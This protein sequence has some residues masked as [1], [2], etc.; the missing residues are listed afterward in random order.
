MKRV[1]YYLQI[2]VL[3]SLSVP[4]FG[5]FLSVNG[6]YKMD[7]ANGGYDAACC[8][9]PYNLVTPD[10]LSN[11]FL[12]RVHSSLPEGTSALCMASQY[13]AS[14]AP[15]ALHLLDSGDVYLTYVGQGDWYE[16]VL[17]FYTFPWGTPP[18]SLADSQVTV[19]FPNATLWSSGGGLAIGN[20]VY[21]GH[22][23]ANTGFGF[24]LISNG[25]SNIYPFDIHSNRWR[26]DS[27]L[28]A[29]PWN[30]N[31]PGSDIFCSHT[32]LNKVAD[33]DPADTMRHV[34]A[35]WDSLSGHIVVGMEDRNRGANWQ[36]DNDFND[37]VFYLTG[38]NA[39][40]FDIT[41]CPHTLVTCDSNTGSGSGGGL[42]S[43]NLGGI[44]AKHDYEKIKNGLPLHAKPDYA[45]TPV[46]RPGVSAAQRV[47]GASESLERFMPSILFVPKSDNLNSSDT[48]ATIPY[49]SSPS[50][51]TQI[52]TAKD[53][54]A[55][56]FVLGSQAKAAA[57]AITTV[58]KAYNHTKSICDR[59]RGATLKS[60]DTIRIQ[61]YRFVLFDMIQPDG[62]NEYSITFD[63]GKNNANQDSLFLQAKWLITQY[64]GYDSVFNFQLWAS[65]PG[66]TIKLVNQVLNNLKTMGSLAQVDDNFV[67]PQTYIANG[68]RIKGNLNISVS[69]ATNQTDAYILFEENKTETAVL[70]TLIVPLTLNQGAPTSVLV[71]INDGYQYEGH[72][73]V[74]GV[75][76]D[77]VY[78][79]DGNWSLDYDHSMDY[80]ATYAP[81]NEPSR[82][83]PEGEYPIYRSV[84][85][86]GTESSYMYAYKFLTAGDEPVDLTGYKSLKF[87]A[88]GSRDVTIKL[89]KNSING[90]QHQYQATV[91]L[92][93]NTRDYQ[94][95][96]DDFTSDSL[97]D[98][99]NA[100]DI[101]AIIFAFDF[102]GVS[103]PF[104]F[105]AGDIAFSPES[106]NSIN[107]SQSKVQTITPNPTTGQFVCSFYSETHRTLELAVSDQN[108]RIFYRQTIQ[109]NTGKNTVFVTLPD[110]IPV[111]NTLMVSLENK[112]VKYKGSKLTLVK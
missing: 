36:P 89:L 53:V 84:N 91:S 86:V 101:N 27:F 80:I 29:R 25:W 40:S 81:G 42:E 92:S 23:P 107:V 108:G 10:T 37:V 112:Q 56:D 110:N 79:A 20:K 35:L 58:K 109:A 24:Y 88:M 44:V 104:N 61:G 99:L 39:N 26:S 28:A 87:S 46:F 98:P 49:Y 93:Q 74:N 34:V 13:L 2:V 14:T 82:T 94:I 90:M 7:T 103:T 75:E 97:A 69:N 66:A 51:L 111:P 105:T 21:L 4:G 6:Q 57:L 33:A 100:K 78:M 65:N 30:G 64:K 102:Y 76:T 70:D 45:R 47:A 15:T 32:Q 41:G 17:C 52:T 8:A 19:V 68:K 60:T 83:Y 9:K 85:V 22:F 54:L 48:V 18:T 55:V 5:Q 11:C 67:L 31:T 63:I 38:N 43:Q 12:T 106:A 73:F 96:F 1:F 77:V 62:T 71:P 16:N 3:L 72:L 50:D 95:S 59:F